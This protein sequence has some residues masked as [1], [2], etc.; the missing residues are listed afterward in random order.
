MS[1]RIE[2][3]KIILST[4]INK[5]DSALAVYKYYKH[6]LKVEN[7]SFTVEIDP[8]NPNIDKPKK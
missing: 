6:K 7:N 4:P 3:N 2:G 5:L 8:D 1:G